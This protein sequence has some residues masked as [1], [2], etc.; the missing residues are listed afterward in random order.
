M[1]VLSDV[2]WLGLEPLI[3]ACRP[4]RKTQHHDLRQ[5]IE[6]IVWRC[7]NGAKGR[8]SVPAEP[9][10]SAAL[11]PPFGTD[12][13][14]AGHGGRQRRLSSA[15]R[16]WARGKS[17]WGWRRPRA[18]A[19]AW[20]SWTAP[21]SAAGRSSVPKGGRR[22]TA[23]APA[24]TARRRAPP[25]GGPCTRAKP[26]FQSHRFA[27]QWPQPWRVWH[28]DRP[29]RSSV[30]WDGRQS[31]PRGLRARRRAWPRPRLCPGAGPSA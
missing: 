29:S 31:L 14:L 11:L 6:A 7:W 30:P 25:K 17:C 3:E 5:T 19:L 8:L 13:R 2:E 10:P 12:D 24:R 4:H 27:L 23:E 20:C 28:H 9:G 16:V 26:P 22:Q 1:A 15:G 21:R 18:C